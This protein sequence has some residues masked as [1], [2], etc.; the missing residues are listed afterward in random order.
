MISIGRRAEFKFLEDMDH[1]I[2]GKFKL[3]Q[4]I[5]SG[6]F[7]ELFLGANAQSGEELLSSWYWFGVEGEYNAMVIDLL[8]PSLEDLFNYWGRKFSLK[9]VLMLADQLMELAEG[10]SEERYILPL[11]QAAVQGNWEEAEKFGISWLKSEITPNKF[12]TL[13][14][15]VLH[16]QDKFV[17]KLLR[18]LDTDDLRKQTKAGDNVLTFAAS[19]G[20]LKIAQLLV[21]RDSELVSIT[22]PDL[23]VITAAMHGRR[24]LV[25]YLHPL[26]PVLKEQHEDAFT[27]LVWCIHHEFFDI[28]LDI[29]QHNVLLATYLSDDNT[30]LRQL[31]SMPW[32]FES[33]NEYDNPIRQ[34]VPTSLNNKA[35][36]KAN[37]DFGMD[38]EVPEKT[39]HKDIESAH[40][41]PENEK[42]IKRKVP[43]LKNIYDEKVKHKRAKKLLRFICHQVKTKRFNELE[44]IQ[45]FRATFIAAK[46]GILE[47]FEEVLEFYPDAIYWEDTKNKKYTVLD[48]AIENR[49][50][51]IFSLY[52]SFGTIKHFISRHTDEENNCMLHIAARMPDDKRLRQITGIALQMQREVQWYEAIEVI[53]PPDYKTMKNAEPKEAPKGGGTTAQFFEDKGCKKFLA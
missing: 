44:G 27:L 45:F 32:A 20:N 30:A 37:F 50:S 51:K 15:A 28:A 25:E 48:Y 52:Y 6:S 49:R 8:G 13:H 33:G 9:T 41:S 18:Y 23:P 12:T 2:G 40:Q 10:E 24:K 16:G 39:C 35:N 17:E 36:H 21:K 42:S 31:M 4:K 3:G 53:I 38:V 43:Y 22:A 11:Y 19:V 7:G 47:F 1:V 29:L 14:W 5:G 46:N 26:T 34:F